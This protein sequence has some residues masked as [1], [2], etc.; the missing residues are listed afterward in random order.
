MHN[1][2]L[3]HYLGLFHKFRRC[4]AECLAKALGE[5]AA[6]GEAYRVH[7]LRHVELA[8]TQQFGC[9]MQTQVTDVFDWCLTSQRLYLA[10]QLL[11]AHAHNLL[12][13]SYIEV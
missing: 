1:T 7:H 2:L 10:I 12:Q 13:A 6:V 3:P 4:H 9:L 11:A 8:G 5:V